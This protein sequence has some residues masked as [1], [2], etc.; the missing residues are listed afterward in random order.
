MT[1][2]EEFLGHLGINNARDRSLRDQM[3]K[4]SGAIEST[5]EERKVENRDEHAAAVRLAEDY[6]GDINWVSKDGE[7][8][9]T[10]CG[11]LSIDGAG[12]TRIYGG[13]YRG[14]QSAFIVNSRITGKPLCLVV[15]QASNIFFNR[16]VL[17]VVL[18]R[19]DGF[20]Y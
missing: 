11:D 13:K 7:V 9:S 15:S 18:P 12:C 1:K 14:R 16:I 2:H 5:F 20:A 3:T 17:C 4:V 6:G 8:H 19:F 10:S